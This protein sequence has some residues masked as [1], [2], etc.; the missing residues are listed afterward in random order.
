MYSE[1]IHSAE[2]TDSL[3]RFATQNFGSLAT[4]DPRNAYILLKIR[5]WMEQ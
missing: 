5:V 1:Y 3:G 4:T 2:C